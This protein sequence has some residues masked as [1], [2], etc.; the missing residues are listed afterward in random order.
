MYKHTKHE[1]KFSSQPGC[2]V[3]SQLLR[4]KGPC[5][6]CFFT[7]H[8]RSEG[9]LRMPVAQAGGGNRLPSPGHNL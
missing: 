4:Q 9:V 5:S 7:Q 8:T 1:F 6:C 3:L 2:R